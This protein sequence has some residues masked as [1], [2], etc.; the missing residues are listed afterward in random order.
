MVKEYIA[1]QKIK[2]GKQKF[3]DEMRMFYDK[4][5]IEYD[6]RYVWD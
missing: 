4:Y 6:E 3:E 1:N 2:H 5:V